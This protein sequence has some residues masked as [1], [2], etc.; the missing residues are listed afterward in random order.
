MDKR[1]TSL[2]SN[3][4]S[5]M[6]YD[7]VGVVYKTC[8]MCGDRLPINDFYTNKKLTSSIGSL[9]GNCRRI[10]KQT[11]MP[12]GSSRAS[13]GIDAIKYQAMLM[14]QC[15]RCA[16]CDEVPTHS[17]HVDHDHKSGKIRG[18]LCRNCNLMIGLAKD[19]RIILKSATHY[20]SEEI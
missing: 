4:A 7:G 19:S 2:A 3:V 13:L 15:G 5:M 8:S 6:P 14:T 20:L 1:Y 16:I 17:L 10:T 11:G 18:L 9:C 12:Y